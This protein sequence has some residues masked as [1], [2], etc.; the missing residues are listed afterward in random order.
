MISCPNPRGC[1]VELLVSTFFDLYLSQLAN[2]AA[3]DHKKSTTFEVS[4]PD[5]FD[6]TYA[7]RS[8]ARGDYFTDNIQLGGVTVKAQTMGIAYN[9][10]LAPGLLG[11][12]YATNEASLAQD[13]PFMYP[14]IIDSLLDQGKINTKV[15]SLYLDDLN[16]ATGNLL[17]GGLDSDKYQG[18]LVSMPIIPEDL[19][20]GTTLYTTF[21]VPMVSMAIRMSDRQTPTKL[22]GSSFSATVLLD[23][24]TTLSYIPQGLYDAILNEIG[25]E[26]DPISGF[27]FVSCSVR[28]NNPGLNFNFEFGEEETIVIRVPGAEL[29]YDME[30]IF[31]TQTPEVSISDPCMLGFLAQDGEPYILGDNFL[32]S[33]YVVYDLK[34]NLIALGQTNFDSTTSSIIDIPAGAT[35]IPV[36]SGVATKAVTAAQKTPTTTA[37]GRIGTQLGDGG[38]ALPT[39]DVE[40]PDGSRNPEGSKNPAAVSRPLELGGLAVLGM[41]MAFALMGGGLFLTF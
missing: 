5:A 3:V 39:N 1:F 31:G 35:T 18:N 2:I 6:I 41:S 26:E 36:R 21:S 32:R 34:N 11:I 29:I 4:H 33:A 10:S 7:D 19:G 8:S 23:S 25:G 17:F 13:P 30:P 15:Y 40:N 22:T 16:A 20:F 12:G 38:S 27:A 28:D 14:S 9:S 24:G 37:S